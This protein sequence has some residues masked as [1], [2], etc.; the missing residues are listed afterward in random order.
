[1]KVYLSS[2][3]KR[4]HRDVGLLEAEQMSEFSWDDT[5]DMINKMRETVAWVG[6]DA[7][8]VKGVGS[9]TDRFLGVTDS[10]SSIKTVIA[11]CIRYGAE[12]DDDAS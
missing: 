1:M 9:N 5:R 6:C 8:F 11:T 4:P 10:P 12:E 3:S 7:I 2:P